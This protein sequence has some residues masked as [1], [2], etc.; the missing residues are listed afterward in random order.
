MGYAQHFLWQALKRSLL[1]I[2]S[3][4]VTHKE[5]VQQA[6]PQQVFH[7]PELGK[8][9]STYTSPSSKEKVHQVE[10]PQ[11]FQVLGS[12][13]EN[14]LKGIEFR[15]EHFITDVS[16]K[17]PQ[18]WALKGAN[19][20]DVRRW[21]GF[22]A[23]ASICTIA[24]DWVL[25]AV[26]ESWHNNPHLKRGDE[27]EIK[28]ITV[29][30]E[31]TTNAIQYPSFHFMKLQRPDKKAFT[32]IKEQEMKPELV[33]NLT[34]DDISTRR[35]W[36]VWVCLTDMDKVKYPFKIYQNSINGSF[37][38][39]SMTGSTTRFAND[40]F[41]QKRAMIWENKLIRT[42]N[43]QQKDTNMENDELPLTSIN[44]HSNLTE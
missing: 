4:S 2:G 26:I 35:A 24:P 23:L 15:P 40:M 3:P 27:L 19:P 42:E 41:E 6:E 17:Y 30:S 14:L 8:A 9:D 18:L 37:L 36:G 43:T 20:N 25:N 32:Y 7:I 38:L 44:L 29:A 5:R 12:G 33:V 34:K 16:G 21:Y 11:G 39:N 22:G 31:D 10:P 28:F 13:Q 1:K